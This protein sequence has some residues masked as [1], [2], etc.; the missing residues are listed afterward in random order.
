VRLLALRLILFVALV[1]TFTTG[2]TAQPTEPPTTPSLFTFALIGDLGYSARQE[3]LL[4][5]LLDELNATP[6]LAFVV[7]DGDLWGGGGCADERYE[8]RLAQFQASVHPFIFTPGDNDWTD[9]HG[10]G[11]DPVDRL[12][13]ERRVFFPDGFSLGQSRLPQIR[14]SDDPAFALYRENARWSF[15]GV[16]FVTVNVAGSRNNFGR[17]DE[18]D[19]EATARTAADLEWLSRSFEAAERENSRAVMIIWQANPGFERNREDNRAFG[20]LLDALQDHSVAYQRPVV[21]VHGDSHYFRIDKPLPVGPT[22]TRTAISNFTRVETFGQP[23]HHWL[24][25]TVDPADPSV[26]TFRQRIVES[27]R[28]CGAATDPC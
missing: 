8:R 10:S 16:T 7:H 18:M 11:F 22:L 14:Q 5:N 23:N 15:G 1:G 13:L 12:N 27:N 6:D 19:A 26:F 2:A 9:C 3:P 4:Q 21:L 20:P 24:S 28:G 25:V 17:T